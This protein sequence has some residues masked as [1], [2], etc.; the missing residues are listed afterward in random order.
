MD[1]EEIF[2]EFFKNSE[3]SMDIDP[4]VWLSKYLIKRLEL[5]KDQI[6][7]FCFLQSV[8]YHLPTAYLIFNE[9]PDSYLA[10]EDRIRE[11]WTR[12]VQSRC[13]YQTDKLKQRKYLPETIKSYQ[14]VIGNSD[15]SYFDKILC[16]DKEEK[17]EVL[18]KEFYKPI[19]HFGRF[20]T[21]NFAQML[22]QVAGY[23]I[24]PD[25]LFL[26]ESN[27]E[28]ITHGMCKV[29]GWDDK[30]FKKRWKTPEG[31]KRKEVYKFNS[32]EKKLMENIASNLVLELKTDKFNL[33]TVL[34]AYKKLFRERDSRYIGYYLDRQAQD[35]NKVSS[36]G[37]DGIPWY[38]LDQARIEIPEVNTVGVTVDKE[39]FK[40]NIEDKIV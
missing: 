12:D 5:N 17:F 18:W 11:W 13:P 34:C 16:G 3:K 28:S 14:E 15:S 22:K 1:R 7:W 32:K 37:W 27:A 36:M 23:D 6:I 2:I 33:E 35:I 10:G 29:I 24:D 31:K 30:T 39:K 19:A 4:G 26:G 21:W 9:Y 20:S 38:L 8:T 25:V 40:W